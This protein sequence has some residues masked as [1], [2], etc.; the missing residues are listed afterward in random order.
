MAGAAA[1][2]T[3]GGWLFVEHGF[4]QGKAVRALLQANGFEARL[5][6]KDLEGQDRVSGGRIRET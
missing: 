5:T 3:P 6:H 1:A 4:D 2:L